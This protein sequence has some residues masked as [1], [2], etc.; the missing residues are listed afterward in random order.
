MGAHLIDGEFQSDKYP[1][2][3]RGKVPLSVKDPTAQDL[4]WEYAQRRRAVDSEFSDDL[5]TALRTAGYVPAPNTAGDDDAPCYYYD[6]NSSYPASMMEPMPVG[7]PVAIQSESDFWKEHEERR[8]A[9]QSAFVECSVSI[10]D[11]CKI[12]PLP[13]LH[14]GKLKFPT[15]SYEIKKT[16]SAIKEKLKKEGRDPTDMEKVVLAIGEIAKLMM[17]SLYGKFAMNPE[18]EEVAVAEA[19]RVAVAS[20]REACA[21]ECE[22]VSTETNHEHWEIVAQTAEMCSYR[23]RARSDGGTRCATCELKPSIKDPLTER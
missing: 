18:R 11:S 7:I 15:G 3:P 1:T 16:A 21:K 5:E 19:V 2:T 9:G 14:E 20:E 17:N 13:H 23:I 12:P 6:R 8:A 4:L 10:P 22:R